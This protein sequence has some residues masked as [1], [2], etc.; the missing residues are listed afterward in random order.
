MTKKYN[1]VPI[2]DYYVVID[3][4]IRS[5][6]TI[7]IDYWNNVL[8]IYDGF[9]PYAPILTT[10]GKRVDSLPLI[11]IP[12]ESENTFSRLAQQM[13]PDHAS[14]R[15]VAKAHMRI[16]YKAATKT[17]TEDQIRLASFLGANYK[18]E[19]TSL[20]REDYVVNILKAAKPIIAVELEVATL[21]QWHDDGISHGRV[22]HN[23]LIADEN[24][25]IH[26]VN[27]FYEDTSK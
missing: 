17:Y 7:S 16:G 27:V 1:V 2:E 14:S 25:I 10:I 18:P 21:S 9:D 15:V 11:E 26:P 6:A 19:S 23:I 20:N 8:S 13:Y 3:K 5:G 4:E 22:E 12:D 24:N